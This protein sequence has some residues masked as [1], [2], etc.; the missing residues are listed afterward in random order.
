MLNRHG[1]IAGATGTGKTKTLQLMAE[2]LSAAG[3][4][5]FLADL[6]G[7]LS[8]L[9]VAGEAERARERARPGHGLRVAAPP[10][11]P[12]EFLS[13]TGKL[14]AQLRATCRRSVRCCS[15]RC[16]ASNETQTSVLTHGL[17]VQRRPRPRAAR[18]RRPARRARAPLGRRRRASSPATAACRRRRSACCCARWSSSSSRARWRSSASPSSTST[19]C[20]RSS[21]T[22]AACLRARARRRAGQA[23]ALLHVHDVDARAPLRDAAR[24]GRPREAQARVLLRRGALAVRGR[25]QGVPRAGRAGGAARALEG[26]RGLLRHA[27]PEGRSAGRARASSATACSTRCARSRPTTRRRCARR[28]APSRGPTFYDVEETLTTLGIGEA[29]VTVLRQQRRADAAVRHA[30]DPARLAHG[31]ARRRAELA[32]R[33]ATPQVRRYAQ[34]VDRESA[35]EKLA[36][37][38]PQAAAG[39]A[40]P[41]PAAHAAAQRRLDRSRRS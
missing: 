21:A 14:G 37:R 8:G 3:V 10:A 39:A 32:A 31:P 7:D 36:R 28:R 9:A 34:A 6:K 19:T 26:R 40:G 24:G 4:P 17:Q 25:E 2:Q 30:A 11:C 29:L 18:L 13:L 41:A 33:L 5:V 22:G 20:S 1:L 16:S 35:E 27:E 23:G 12:V 15:P 38:E